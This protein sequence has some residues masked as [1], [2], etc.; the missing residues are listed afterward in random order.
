LLPWARQGAHHVDIYH[1]EGDSR[2]LQIIN[3]V[4]L[5]GN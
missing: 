1:P 5:V 4:S 3:L 2:T